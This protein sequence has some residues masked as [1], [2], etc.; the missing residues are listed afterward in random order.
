MKWTAEAKVGFVTIVAVLLFVF[1]VLTL[2]H[3]EVFG[4]P[5]FE[6]H[7]VFHDANGIQK[8]NAVRYVGVNVGKVERVATSKDGVE[9]TMKL[10]DGTEIPKDS[11]VSITTDGLLG[12]KI[13]SFAAGKDKRHI[14]ADGDFIGGDQAKTMD[15]MMESASTL[16][17]SANE[18]VK[19]LNNI[20]GDP[21]SQA[22]LRGTLQNIETITGNVGDM[23][24]KASNMMDANAGNIQQMTANMADMT[25]QMNASLSRM[26]GDGAMSDNAR[27]TMAN[28]K[29]ATDNFVTISNS[30]KDM[31]TD[32]KAQ[33]NIQTTLDNAAQITTKV[34]N[35]LGGEGGMKVKGD[36]SLLYNDTKDKTGGQVNFRLYRNNSFALIGAEDI[37]NG[38][39]M[40]F[41]L[42][43]HSRLFDTRVGLIHGDLGA[44]F[45]FFVNSPF[46]LT[47]EGY[48][49]ND[50]RYRI[51]AKYRIM[52]DVYLFGQFTRPMQRSDGG[53]Y[54]GL[55]YTF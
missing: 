43:R 19:N 13:I 55:E 8:G 18:M 54:Y 2:A 3:T 17:A 12:E 14:L 20:V 15:D 5:G 40:N 46:R 1:V 52:P 44:G 41:Q 39:D 29:T 22:A 28:I 32:P 4:K 36:A 23:T 6:V 51:K 34:N 35:F 48:D 47:L 10:D 42:G 24:G 53:N 45:D 9:V 27:Q 11:K 26:D 7:A 33:A 38:T 30:L 31:T 16:M 21:K 25:S 50:W 37:G 49:P